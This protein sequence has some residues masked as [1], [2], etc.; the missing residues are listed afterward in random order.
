[1]KKHLRQIKLTCLERQTN[2]AKLSV[3][4]TVRLTQCFLYISVTSVAK[5]THI[6]VSWFLTALGHR[7][8]VLPGTP[9]MSTVM[10]KRVLKRQTLESRQLDK[11]AE[12]YN[13]LDEN[14]D[15]FLTPN[16]LSNSI[17]KYIHKNV[18]DDD[19]ETKTMDVVDEIGK[20]FTVK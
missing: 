6:A 5:R 19:D 7:N 10:V 12:V 1:M 2:I 8:A 13:F 11:L 9:Y 20:H 17:R 14:G 3:K 16:E 15:G 18:E 4:D